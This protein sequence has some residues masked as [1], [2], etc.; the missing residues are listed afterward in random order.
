MSIFFFKEF[1][2]TLLEYTKKIMFGLS[3]NYH[4]VHGISQFLWLQYNEYKY[5]FVCDHDLSQKN[6]LKESWEPLA[7]SLQPSGQYLRFLFKRSEPV[8][9]LNHCYRESKLCKIQMSSLSELH[10][11]VTEMLINTNKYW[12]V[13]NL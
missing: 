2:S 6:Y 12:A 1:G 9:F 5:F 4:F 3:Q 10:T 7:T 13:I 11:I 8:F